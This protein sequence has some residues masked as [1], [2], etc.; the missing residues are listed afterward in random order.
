MRR[1][2]TPSCKASTKRA[3]PTDRRGS[4]G[5]VGRL[6][7]VDPPADDHQPCWNTQAALPTGPVGA[8]Y[9]DG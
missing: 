8:V 1:L 3:L 6:G 4:D 2:K 5:L 9:A 7:R